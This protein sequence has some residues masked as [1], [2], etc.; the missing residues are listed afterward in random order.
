MAIQKITYT[1]KEDLNI[2][3]TVP[4]INKVVAADMNEIKNVIN[5]NADELEHL[6]VPPEI[7]VQTTQPSDDGIKLWINPNKVPKGQGFL[8][9]K[10]YPIGSIYINTTGVNPSTFIGG[11]WASFGAGKVLVGQDTN[12]TNFDTLLETG[13]EPTH[14]LTIDEIPSHN[15]IANATVSNTATAFGDGYLGTSNSYQLNNNFT[16]GSTG[17]GL[18]HN[19]LQ[20][21]IVVSMWVRTA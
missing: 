4:V 8:L 20:P 21:Y 7:A 6:D 10:I 9:D 3:P 12:D 5:N 14:T 2:D 17:G 16:T 1:N 18:A 15:H 11:T 19:N 13:G